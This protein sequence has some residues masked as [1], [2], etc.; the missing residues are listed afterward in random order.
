MEDKMKTMARLLLLL[1]CMAM[2]PAA[3]AAADFP[4]RPIRMVVPFPPGAASDF[5]ARVVAQKLGELY[6][7]QVIVD[8]RPGGGGAIGTVIIARANPDG[9]TISLIGTPHVVNPLLYEKPPFH[10]IRDFTPIIQVSS[11]PNILIVGIPVN[12]VQELIA[13]AKSKPGQ[14]NFASAGVGSLSYMAG[15]LFKQAAGIQAQNVAFKMLGDAVTEMVAGRVHF[16]VIPVAAGMPLIKDGKLRPLAVTIERRLESLPNVPTM[17][18]AGLPNFRFDG[19]FGVA[20]PAKMPA[21]LVEKLNRDI[22][23]ILQQADTRERFVRQG[24]EAVFGTPEDFHKL[25]VSEY[26]R[27]EKVIKEA[28]IKIQ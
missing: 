11:L 25:M 4:V 21:A 13:L 23:G 17:A 3:Y 7:Q 2:L 26:A 9:Y 18:E 10:P 15:E 6:G 19:W 8:T 12:S 22:A 5:F 16:Y 20:G 24:S 14:L 28:G 27:F 1:A